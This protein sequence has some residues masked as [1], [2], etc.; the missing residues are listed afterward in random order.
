MLQATMQQWKHGGQVETSINTDNNGM[1]E[2]GGKEATTLAT[3]EG[4][5]NWVIL[6]SVKYNLELTVCEDLAV[7]KIIR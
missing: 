5:S 2:C 6:H 3:L 1:R 4:I 7:L